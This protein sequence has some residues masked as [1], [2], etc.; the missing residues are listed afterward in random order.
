MDIIMSTL[1]YTSFSSTV[2]KICLAS[3]SR[4]ICW[5]TIDVT[6][7]IPSIKDFLQARYERA[8]IPAAEDHTYIKEQLNAYLNGSLKEFKCTID[9]IEGTS[10]QKEVWRATHKI[11]FGSV[12]TYKEIARRITRPKTFR[13]VGQALGANPIAIIVPCHRVISSDGTLGGF[14]LGLELKKHLL[15]LE[16]IY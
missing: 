12:V 10:F 6:K 5:L 4:G 9:F 3:T 2:G 7:R 16:G 1:Q 14:G 15:T 13:A 8:A 11:P